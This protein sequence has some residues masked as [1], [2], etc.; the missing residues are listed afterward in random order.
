MADVKKPDNVVFNEKAKTYDAA[1]KPYGT[2]VGAPSIK[3]TDTIAWKNK[4]ITKLNHNIERRY[5]ELKKQYNLLMEEIEHNNLVYS[6][7]FTF[8]P[9]IGEVYHLYE[10][11]NGETFLSILSPNQCDFNPLGS[12]LINSDY[13]WEKID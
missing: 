4:G 13:L 12:F 11:G 8:E 7:K 1:L 6:S 3:T 9:I 10:R 5:Q 2:N